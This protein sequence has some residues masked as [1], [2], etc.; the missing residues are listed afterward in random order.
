M[1]SLVFSCVTFSTG[2]QA[3]EKA[4]ARFFVILI[5]CTLRE[6]AKRAKSQGF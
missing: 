5:L 3:I 6:I 4:V 2:I 1:N